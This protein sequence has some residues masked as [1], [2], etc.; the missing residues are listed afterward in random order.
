[1]RGTTLI[2]R[3]NL[4]TQTRNVSKRLM[5]HIALISPEPSSSKI[6]N[7]FHHPLSLL[8]SS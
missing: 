6:H 1:M 3:I 2:P 5:L 4:G 8:K 7:S